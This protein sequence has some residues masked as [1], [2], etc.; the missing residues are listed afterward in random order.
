MEHVTINIILTVISAI[1]TVFAAFIY[2]YTLSELKRQREN[3]SR[4]HLFIDKISFHV[5]GIKKDDFI[6]PLI[7][8]SDNKYSE[9][10]EFNNNNIETSNFH[11]KCYNIGFGT[12]TNIEINFSYSINEFLNEILELAK[13]V[14][15][16][17]LVK[18]E[19]MGS[20]LNFSTENDSMPYRNI[21]ISVDNNLKHYLSYILPVSIKNDFV[22]VRLPSHFLELLNIYVFYFSLI[23]DKNELDI[24]IPPITTRIEYS[25]INKKIIIDLFTITIELHAFGIAGYH[26]QFLIHKKE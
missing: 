8:S 9:I 15:Q 18:I 6:M 2:Y 25:D 23:E 5:K 4:P 22:S 14:S 21:G 26:G 13:H 20:F 19:R 3:T 17:K 1:A 16:D 10:I 7:W 12:A 24:S 11:L